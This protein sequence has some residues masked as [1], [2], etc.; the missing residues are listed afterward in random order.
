MPDGSDNIPGTQLSLESRMIGDEDI[1][2]P[3]EHLQQM[4]MNNSVIAEKTLLNS[5][6]HGNICTD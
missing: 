2:F 3:A 4:H 5:F 1:Y 6:L